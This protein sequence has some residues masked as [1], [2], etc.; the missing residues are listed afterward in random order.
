MNF[1]F[2]QAFTGRRWRGLDGRFEDFSFF[3]SDRFQPSRGQLQPVGLPGR[4]IASPNV[5][6]RLGFDLLD[7]SSSDQPRRE[8]Q[9]CRPFRL[10]GAAAQRSSRRAAAPSI[11]S[12][13]SV[14][15]VDMI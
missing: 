8:L 15:L 14:S 10:G 3:N 1:G 7:Q 5:G 2:P 13:A 9:R 4:I 11:R 6:A 12:C